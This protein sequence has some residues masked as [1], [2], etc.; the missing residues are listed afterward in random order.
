[1]RLQWRSEIRERVFK[2]EPYKRI[3]LYT[4]PQ[5]IMKKLFLLLLLIPLTGVCQTKNV[6]NMTRLQPKPEKTL[7]LEKALAAHAQKFHTGDWKWRI[8]EII[9]GPEVGGYHIVEGF[10][11]WTTL[12][13]RGNL[14]PDHTA[15]LQ[16]NIAPLTL[17]RGTSDFFLFREDLS[18]VQPT[19]YSDKVS[20]IYLYPKPGFGP[21]IE[22]EIKR[23]KKVWEATGESVAVYQSHFSGETRYGFAYRHKQGWK[24][25]EKDFRKPFKE[26]YI[27]MFGENGYNDRLKLI[28][29]TADRTV[30]EMLVFRADLSSK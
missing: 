26:R 21:K 28:Q 29:E 4:K 30:S 23:D 10:N 17:G 25:K 6:V 9:T 20:V 7:E 3:I 8:F 1:M 18:S 2:F 16:K 5:S 27:A 19:D 11:N 14:G 24:E 22:E 13:G 15:D 12:D